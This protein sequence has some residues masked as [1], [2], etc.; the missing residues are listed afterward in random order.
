MNKSYLTL[1]KKRIFDIT[2]FAMYW[3]IY[4]D[5][6]YDN[7]YIAMGLAIVF[8]ISA[9]NIQNAKVQRMH[10]QTLCIPVWITSFQSSF[11]L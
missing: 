9:R 2:L 8:S 6:T 11:F 10:V 4:V 3:Y 5:A 1:K 7:A